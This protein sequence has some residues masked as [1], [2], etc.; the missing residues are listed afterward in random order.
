VILALDSSG[1]VASVALH[2]GERCRRE[3]TVEAPRGR[4]GALFSA[5][6]ELLAGAPPLERV[7]TGTGPGSYNGIRAA[8]AAGWGVAFARQVPL[9]GVCSLEGLGDGTFCA[10]GDARRG[11]FYFAE[12]VDGILTAEPV[13]LGHSELV[14]RVAGRPVLAP[15]PLPF[16]PDV[17][18]VHPQAARLA[19]VGR[20]RPVGP[21]LP[22]PIYLK[23]P[24][25]TEARSETS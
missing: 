7:V 22:E 23:P 18:L 11:Q 14:T 24:F 3:I 6:A 4:G 21:G 20:S 10:A 16:L 1:L 25:I 15:G 12:I 9:V 13:L 8:I 17:R 2:D 5:L 19:W